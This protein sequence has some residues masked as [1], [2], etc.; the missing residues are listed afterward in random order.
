MESI[1]LQYAFNY[2]NKHGNSEFLWKQKHYQFIALWLPTMKKWPLILQLISI[3]TCLYWIQWLH[4]KNNNYKI[5][6]EARPSSSTRNYTAAMRMDPTV[7]SLRV[8]NSTNVYSIAIHVTFH[9]LR[10]MQFT[11]RYTF[12]THCI[13]GSG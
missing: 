8:W 5:L 2:D 12:M 11:Y 10:A 6:M 4:M 9:E 1:I 13:R 3:A 7:P